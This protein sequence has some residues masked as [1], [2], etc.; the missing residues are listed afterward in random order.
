LF[1]RSRAGLCHGSAGADSPEPAFVAVAEKLDAARK[2]RAAAGI[3]DD[4]EEVSRTGAIDDVV[5]GVEEPVAAVPFAPF[6][7]SLVSV[8]S[9]GDGALSQGLGSKVT[10]VLRGRYLVYWV[11]G[12]V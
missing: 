6:E 4:L 9:V 3:D 12:S 10:F 1:R 2:A 5:E 7:Q 11:R 8:D